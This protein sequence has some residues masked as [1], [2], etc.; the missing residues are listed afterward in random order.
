VQQPLKI[1]ARHA[2]IRPLHILRPAVL[3]L[4]AVFGAGCYMFRRN[5]KGITGRVL[6]P[7]VKRL[8]ATPP[9]PIKFPSSLLGSPMSAAMSASERARGGGQVD[10]FSQACITYKAVFCEGHWYGPYLLQV[11][12]MPSTAGAVGTMGSLAFGIEREGKKEQESSVGPDFFITRW[13][14]RAALVTG[15]PLAAAKRSVFNHLQGNLAGLVKPGGADAGLE[16]LERWRRLGIDRSKVMYDAGGWWGRT[17]QPAFH[18]PIDAGELFYFETG[19]PSEVIADAMAVDKFIVVRGKRLIFSATKQGEVQLIFGS[20]W[21]QGV[22]QVEDP[23]RA[24][25]FLDSVLYDTVKRNNST[26]NYDNS[27]SDLVPSNT[28][29]K[30]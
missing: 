30:Y 20:G 5:P 15:A 25:V 2:A 26:M 6:A 11:A 27:D 8:V 19:A 13:G 18:T 17:E 4:L 1:T 14:H 21:V 16:F 7:E 24:S 12:V 3:L 29:K 10:K 22:S 9:L 28:G 23:A